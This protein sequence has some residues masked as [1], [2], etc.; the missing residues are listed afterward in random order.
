M[1][2]GVLVVMR[3]GLMPVRAPRQ[4]LVRSYV[5]RQDHVET[6][7]NEYV[8]WTFCE[9]N[10]GAKNI[11]GP[12]A[13]VSILFASLHYQHTSTYPRVVTAGAITRLGIWAQRFAK[14]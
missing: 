9:N 2:V 8:H 11:Q 10:F 12:H 6:S 13:A 14:K 5:G 7:T 4:F 1:R 3:G